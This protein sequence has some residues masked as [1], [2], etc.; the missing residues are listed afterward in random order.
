MSSYGACM[1]V[2]SSFSCAIAGEDFVARFVFFGIVV[3]VSLLI[4]IIAIKSEEIRRLRKML[5]MKGRH[6]NGCSRDEL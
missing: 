2:E 1:I 6:R 4:F 3:T 5:M